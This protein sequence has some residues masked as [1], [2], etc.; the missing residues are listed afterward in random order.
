M[1]ANPVYHNAG[2]PITL[3]IIGKAFVK[4]AQAVK[5]DGKQDGHEIFTT[6]YQEK[7]E[8]KPGRKK[9]P[10]QPTEQTH[11]WTP[12]ECDTVLHILLEKPF[13]CK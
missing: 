5:T 6:T 7:S 12:Q 10:C 4:T 8:G 3:K 11:H 9:C 13:T 2:S 1:Q